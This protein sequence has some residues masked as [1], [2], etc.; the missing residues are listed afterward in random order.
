MHSR[1]FV[2]RD[3]K[4]EFDF[5]VPTLNDLQR[6]VDYIDESDLK[7]DVLWLSDYYL[8]EVKEKKGKYF[9]DRNDFLRV[10]ETERIR[11]LRKAKEILTSKPLFELQASEIWDTCNY[12]SDDSGF[13][14]IYNRNPYV[15]GPIELSFELINNRNKKELEIVKSYDYY[16]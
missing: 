2:L 8:I 15:E 12:L 1:I 7:D 16:F 13:L 4:G 10:L 6:A 9:M 3:G 5:Y 11:K 14:F